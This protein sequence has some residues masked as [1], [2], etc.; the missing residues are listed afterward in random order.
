MQKTTT[1]YCVKLNKKKCKYLSA[2]NISHL[3]ATLTQSDFDN[4]IF[5]DS[6]DTATL[7]IDA[8]LNHPDC[9]MLKENAKFILIEPYTF[10][11]TFNKFP[12]TSKFKLVDTDK[13]KDKSHDLFISAY[14]NYGDFSGWCVICPAAYKSL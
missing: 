4:A 11:L 6:Y 9:K 8:Y 13:L 14:L 7:A 12:I 5:F 3:P 1:L 2:A 10:T